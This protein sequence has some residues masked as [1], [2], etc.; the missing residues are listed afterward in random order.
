MSV[1]NVTPL[2]HRNTFLF[3]NQSLT[4][5]LLDLG[6]GEGVH[7]ITYWMF[8]W[9]RAVWECF[10]QHFTDTQKDQ[11][12]IRIVGAYRCEVIVGPPVERLMVWGGN[13]WYEMRLE[14]TWS[15]FSFFSFT[16][17]VPV[18]WSVCFGLHHSPMSIFKLQTFIND[19]GCEDLSLELVL[20]FGYVK[21]DFT[22][23][24][25]HSLEPFQMEK[26]ICLQNK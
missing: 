1:R 14:L 13:K 16:Y 19:C 5:F 15:A 11:F 17:L 22:C 10:L 24:P 8:A 20:T 18:T 6:R 2:I 21:Q 25:P 12:K 26:R 7:C 4:D 23:A 3:K 9:E